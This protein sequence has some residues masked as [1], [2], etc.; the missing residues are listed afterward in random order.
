[1]CIQVAHDNGYTRLVFLMNEPDARGRSR[2]LTTFRTAQK[3]LQAQQQQGSS[4]VYVCMHVCL[5]AV[6]VCVCVCRGW[7]ARLVCVNPACEGIATVCWFCWRVGAFVFMC[8]FCVCLFVCMFVLFVVQ[9]ITSARGLFSS[10]DR[11]NSVTMDPAFAC[12]YRGRRRRQ[13]G[14]APADPRQYEGRQ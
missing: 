10:R 7:R 5:Q 4:G 2:V 11:I 6:C 3:M 13:Q 8:V 1:M 14:I 12:V 9:L